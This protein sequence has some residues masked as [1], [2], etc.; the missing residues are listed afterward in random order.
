MQVHMIHADMS[1]QDTG[2]KTLVL[3]IHINCRLLQSLSHFMIVWLFFGTD[4]NC[5]ENL[6]FIMA[7][8]KLH[9]IYCNV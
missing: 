7:D 3:H 2:P 8:L 1:H 4:V 6:Q 9:K 5:N